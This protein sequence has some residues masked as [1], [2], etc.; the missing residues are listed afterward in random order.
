VE[1]K[2]SDPASKIM[3]LILPAASQIY[4]Q[5]LKRNLLIEG[6]FKNADGTLKVNPLSR[7][8]VFAGATLEISRELQIGLDPNLTVSQPGLA[9]EGLVLQ[10]D[11]QLKTTGCAEVK[12]LKGASLYLKKAAKVSIGGG[13]FFSFGTNIIA[14]Q[15]IVI[16]EGCAVSWHVTIID[17][18]MHE[19]NGMRGSSPI[20]IGNCV[21]IGHGVSILPGVEIGDGSV[22]A[23]G[24]IVTKSFPKNVTIAGNPAR[25]IK[26]G[27]QWSI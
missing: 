21:W 14:T 8:Q 3:N 20:R 6:S 10:K 24:A 5:L 16:G 18:N 11:A 2:V 22:V 23:A 19:L 12:M 17:A 1:P 9:R 7:F 13:S 27:T 26:E 15:E 25:V 4:G